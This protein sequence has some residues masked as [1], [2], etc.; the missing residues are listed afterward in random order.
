MGFF[1]DRRGCPGK[2]PGGGLA[3]GLFEVNR[4][5]NSSFFYTW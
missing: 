1:I 4:K 3:G 2:V 5:G